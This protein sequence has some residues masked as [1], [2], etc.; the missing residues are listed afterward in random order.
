MIVAL[1]VGV[2]T[3]NRSIFSFLAVLF[4]VALSL[5]P[6][7]AEKRLALVIGINDYREVPK[8]EKAVGD[9]DAVGDKLASLGFQVTKAF[10]PDRR[11]LNLALANL[12]SAIEPGDTVL[13]QYSGHGVEID[14]QNY[15]LPADIP[16][17]QSGQ[18]DLLKSEALSLS[19]LVDTLGAKGAGI[20]ILI[21]DACRDNPFVA[22][23][24]RSL[25]STR[26]LAAV[27]PPKGT[28]IMYS[29]GAG[30]SALDRLDDKD[31]SATSVYTRVLLSRFDTPGLALR[32]LAAN[33]REDVDR[34]SKSV[35]HEQRPA[36]Y[37]DLPGEFSFVP[38]AISATPD[39]APRRPTIVDPVVISRPASQ[40]ADLGEEQAFKLSQT[41]DTV[42]SWD[43]FLKQYP[44]GKYAP[45]ASAAK[46]KI[47]S[48]LPQK[49][50]APEPTL[51]GA[52]RS[53][54]PDALALSTKIWPS[55]TISFEQ[56]VS[57][58]T[59]YGTLICVGG[60][61]NVQ[62]RCHWK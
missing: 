39:A 12:Y 47:L 45:Y 17:P 54:R 23:G 29:A 56:M 19:S 2:K 62:R 36:Y 10:N 20:R 51:Q 42:D 1:G 34:L 5:S 49:N 28:F 24:K 31:S 30:Q 16:A 27:E 22:S 46:N 7:Q 14:G 11:T 59:K 58:V 43:V 33:V 40:P 18:I 61:Q 60:S 48:M 15:L 26:G 9:A 6:A 41:I 3:M 57:S 13:V 38:Q 37:D 4:F 44:S 25:G 50:T 8:L 32:D 53:S 52:G 35:G 55:H 21:V